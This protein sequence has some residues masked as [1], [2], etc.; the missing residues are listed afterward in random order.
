MTNGSVRQFVCQRLHARQVTLGNLGHAS[1]IF[2]VGL[3]QERQ[4]DVLALVIGG[5]QRAAK[6]LD[7]VLALFLRERAVQITGLLEVL[8]ALDLRTLSYRIN[9]LKSDKHITIKKI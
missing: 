5:R 9:W 7:Q 4:D 6:V 3:V 2:R 1:A 8:L